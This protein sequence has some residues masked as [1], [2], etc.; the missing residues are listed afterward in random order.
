MLLWLE[1]LDLPEVE[2]NHLRSGVEPLPRFVAITVRRVSAFHAAA[3]YSLIFFTVG[4][5]PSVGD[6]LYAPIVP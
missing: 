4:T 1:A 3:P 5:F 6:D 2:S